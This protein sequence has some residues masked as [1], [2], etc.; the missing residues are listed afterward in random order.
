MIEQLNDVPN[1]NYLLFKVESI[2]KRS[3]LKPFEEILVQYVEQRCFYCGKSLRKE[4][5]QT[6]VDPSIPWSFVQSDQLWN[7]V[8]TC[9][10]CNT[11]KRDKLPVPLYLDNV[12]DRNERLVREPNLVARERELVT[13]KKEKIIH[14]YDYSIQNG[15]ENIWVP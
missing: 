4:S 9:S 7:L 13:Y 10:T 1:I 14:L 8:L 3:S 6:H 15:Y 2:A 5:V 11:S 12:V